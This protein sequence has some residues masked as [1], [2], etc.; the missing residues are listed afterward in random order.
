MRQMPH[1]GER[2]DA[3]ERAEAADQVTLMPEASDE[4][5]E[6]RYI[7]HRNERWRTSSGSRDADKQTGARHGRPG[8]AHPGTG[9]ASAGRVRLVAHGAPVSGPDDE[10]DVGED[11]VPCRST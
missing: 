4:D 3:A 1:I 10:F 8:D 11:L 9:A 6:R 2:A 5:A 7:D